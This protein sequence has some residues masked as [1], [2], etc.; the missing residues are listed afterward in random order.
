[1][2][3]WVEKLLTEYNQGKNQLTK[4]RDSLDLE[5]KVQ[6][7]ESLIVEGMISD[8]QYS[9]EWL[10]RGRRPGDMHGAD[11][12]DVYRRRVRQRELPG[13][14]LYKRQG[15]QEVPPHRYPNQW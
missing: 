3:L 10:R 2:Q 8:M 4:Y 5:D 12:K 7:E 13:T 6:L 1:M 9:I 11:R 15:R 14:A